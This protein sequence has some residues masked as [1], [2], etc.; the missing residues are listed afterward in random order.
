MLVLLIAVLLLRPCSL[1]AQ[2]PAVCNTPDSLQTKTCCPNNCS[3]PTRG[4]CQNIT[5][6]VVAQWEL[7]DSEVNEILRNTPN[8]PQK[9]TADARYLWPTVVFERVC[10]CSRNYGG[11]NCSEYDFGWTGTDCSTRKTPVIRKSFNRL[12]T[13]E[14]Q[15]L[16]NATRDLK[17]E[18]GYWSV[19]VGE[20]SKCLNIQLIHL[21]ARLC[22]AR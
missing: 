1:L 22:Y 15:T 11:V 14:K 18:M 3:G 12:T 8:E 10:V 16:I 6:R 21:L 4:N 13:A 9:G 5:A 7:A 19:I 20:P 2:F 17:K